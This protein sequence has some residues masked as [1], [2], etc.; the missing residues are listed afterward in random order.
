MVPL[1]DLYAISYQPC[2]IS[3]ARL[4]AIAKANLKL[5]NAASFCIF[6]LASKAGM[7]F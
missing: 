4:R 5:H 6:H 7:G 1:L 3:I 2:A